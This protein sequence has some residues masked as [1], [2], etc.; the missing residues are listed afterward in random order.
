MKNKLF[1]SRVAV[2][3]T[4]HHKEKVISPILEP[5]LGI[6]VRV[7][8]NFNSDVFG[9]FTREVKRPVN[10]INAA[11]LKAEKALKLT[12]ET[13]GIASEG[14]FAPHP[15]FPYIYANREIVIF[16]DTENDLEIIGEAFS[17]ET[18]FQHQVITN[19]LEAE[20]FAKQVGFPEHG[21]V[22]WFEQP[23]KNHLEIIKGINTFENLLSS[24]NFA[25]DHSLECQVHLET[26]MRALYNP[27]RMQNIAKATHDLLNKLNSYCPN[28]SL[29]GFSITEKIP[30]LPCEI[31]DQP[32]PLIRAVIYQCQKCGFSREKLFPHGKEFA[33][34][35]Q[36]I[37]CNP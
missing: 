4:M 25:L 30:G 28:C 17:T 13:L 36:C 5:E 9:T 22:I 34:P 21:I 26:D 37:Y 1:N 8:E 18:N 12:G 24:V 3:A 27:L 32:T 7:P 10:Q 14:S 6:K 16:L 15:H 11:R 29:P 35:A 19:L 33:D 20:N 2:L 31:C 23:N